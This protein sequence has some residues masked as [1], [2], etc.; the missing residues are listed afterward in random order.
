MTCPQKAPKCGRRNIS[1]TTEDAE[2]GSRHALQ[3]DRGDAE[4]N[5]ETHES[6]EMFYLD[7]NSEIAGC[8]WRRSHPMADCGI[9]A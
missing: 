9:Q 5:H 3:V 8:A 7:P 1:V 6:H 2:P 4:L